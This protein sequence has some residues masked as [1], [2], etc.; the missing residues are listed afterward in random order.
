MSFLFAKNIIKVAHTRSI[1]LR[2]YNCQ[3]TLLNSINYHIIKLM[4]NNTNFSKSLRGKQSLLIALWNLPLK[5]K[6]IH[7]DNYNCRWHRIQFFTKSKK[8]FE[9]SFPTRENY[10]YCRGSENLQFILQGFHLK[11]TVSSDIRGCNVLERTQY[12]YL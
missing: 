12:H 5:L 9:S 4:S 11:R 7:P 1:L 10:H 8:V 6:T 3:I 2:Q